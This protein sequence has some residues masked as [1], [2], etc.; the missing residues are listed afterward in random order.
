MDPPAVAEEVHVGRVEND[1]AALAGDVLA[2]GDARQDDA[3]ADPQVDE[4]HRAQ[5]AN[6]GD[7]RFEPHPVVGRRAADE[8]GTDPDH[9]A[10]LVLRGDRA[11]QPQEVDTAEAD[12][13]VAHG[14]G[15][16]VHS[17]RSDEVADEGVVRPLEELVGRALL[18]HL[19]VVHHHDRVGERERLGLVVGDVDEGVVELGLHPLE[20]LAQRATSA[21][22]RSPSAAR[23]RGS[24]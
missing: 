16:E 5:I 20:H 10:R 18:H 15:N 2:G 7:G 24:P 6:A 8:V 1:P 4:V 13:P 23:R 21:A 3:V 22:D 12:D 11:G 17:R 9:V 14:A 19:A